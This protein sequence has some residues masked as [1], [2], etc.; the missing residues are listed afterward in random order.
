MSIVHQLKFRAQ[1]ERDLL[2]KQPDYKLLEEQAVEEIENLKSVVENVKSWYYV[3]M[4]KY[5]SFNSKEPNLE[6]LSKILKL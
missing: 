1:R 5:H 3:Q 6:E 2:Y 4:E